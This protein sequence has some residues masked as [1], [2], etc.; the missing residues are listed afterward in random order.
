M[1]VD[2]ICQ[3]FRLNTH[4]Q[5]A[6]ADFTKTMVKKCRPENWNLFSW[7]LWEHPKSTIIFK[8]IAW[9]YFAHFVVSIM[10]STPPVPVNH[11]WIRGDSRTGSELEK[12]RKKVGTKS[13]F[14]ADVAT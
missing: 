9:C 10:Q 2:N 1:Q 3:A 8:G 14:F 11:Q 7:A 13:L 12:K 6:D 5:S 4:P